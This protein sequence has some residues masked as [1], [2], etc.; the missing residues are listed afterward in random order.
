MR[1]QDPVELD[2]DVAALGDLERAAQRVVAAGEVGGHLLGRLEVE[3]VGLEAP[4]VRVLERVA[5]LDAEQRLVRVRV[6]VAQVV[7]VAGGDRRQPALLGERDELRVDPLLHVEVRVLELDVDVVAPEDLLEPVELRLG[8][9]RAALLERLAD[10]AG[11]AARERDQPGAV[12]LEQLPVDAR[13]VVVALEVAE[14]GELDQ[15]RVALVRLGEEREVRL[16]L[17]LR[18]PVVGDVDLAADER[19]DAL[20]SGRLVE[21]DRA[22]E[23]AVVGEPDGRHLE[24][25][26]ALREVRD[27]A[28]AVE[29]RVLGVDVEV[30]EGR[31]G[32]GESIV[33]GVPADEVSPLGNGE[34]EV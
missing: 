7:D 9:G 25:G 28:G 26:G 2:L 24:L 21:V 10:A 30:D 31:F 19:L 17:L 27:P 22:G 29:D 6:L 13:L 18:V 16:A 4:A 23:R 1:Q 8:V 5:R 20:V 32:H 14:R 34:R 12:P 3:V 15:V 33:L 11:E